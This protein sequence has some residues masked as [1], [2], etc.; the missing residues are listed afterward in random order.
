M[1]SVIIDCPHQLCI[2]NS[3]NIYGI[4]LAYEMLPNQSKV[5]MKFRKNNVFAE[6]I[7]SYPG[8]FIGRKFVRQF[9]EG[10]SY[11]PVHF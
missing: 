7:W 4:L 3:K 6:Q 8:L 11:N 5:K 1:S 2:A 10:R 9:L